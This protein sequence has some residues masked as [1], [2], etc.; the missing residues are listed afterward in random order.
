MAFEELNFVQLYHRS[1]HFFKN[2]FLR[3]EVPLFILISVFLAL[4]YI[5]ISFILEVLNFS[6]QIFKTCCS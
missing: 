5:Y 2:W 1:G 3:P 6:A 4:V